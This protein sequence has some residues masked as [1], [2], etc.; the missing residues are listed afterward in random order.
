MD[1]L[2]TDLL[3][4]SDPKKIEQ[5]I[6]D[7]IILLK[8][9]KS[10]GAIHNYVSAIIAFYKINDIVLNVSKIKRFMPE[11][12]KSNKDRGYTREEILKLLEFADERMRTVILILASTGMRIGAIPSLT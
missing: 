2:D 1:Y 6:I 12:R 5:S 3:Q 8:K 7:F 4:K 10:Y 11:Q 9:T